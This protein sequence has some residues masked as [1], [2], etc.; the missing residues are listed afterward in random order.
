MMMEIKSHSKYKKRAKYREVL[1]LDEKIELFEAY[2]QNTIKNSD[3]TS[4]G[5]TTNIYTSKPIHESNFKY[6]YEVNNLKEP[7]NLIEEINSIINRM[8]NLFK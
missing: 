5:L 8:K 1:S 3:G 2:M 6:S 4:A 7:Q